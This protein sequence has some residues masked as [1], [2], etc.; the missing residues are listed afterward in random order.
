MSLQKKAIRQAFVAPCFMR[1]KYR[2]AVCGWP[3][4]S[5]S[6]DEARKLL[7]VHHI[8]PRKSLPNGGYVEQNGITLCRE[9]GKNCHLEAEKFYMSEEHVNE[10]YSPDA[11]FV[12]INSSRDQ[13]LEASKKL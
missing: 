7:D 4:H 1:D 10:A 8:L 11:L 6:F 12:I 3:G 2:C 9:S 5:L 13:A